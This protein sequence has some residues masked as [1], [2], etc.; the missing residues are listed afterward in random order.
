MGYRADMH[1][2]SRLQDVC[3]C[4][5]QEEELYPRQRPEEQRLFQLLQKSYSGARYKQDLEGNE[6]DVQRIYNEVGTFVMRVYE[7]CEGKIE[8]LAGLDK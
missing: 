4:Y 6:N 3:L 1:N 2:L 7:M 5:C 8:E